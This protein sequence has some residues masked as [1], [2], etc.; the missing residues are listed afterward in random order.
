MPKIGLLPQGLQMLNGGVVSRETMRDQYAIA[1]CNL[2]L[3]I[4]KAC[5]PG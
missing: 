2:K 5:K 1:I 3:G 4:T